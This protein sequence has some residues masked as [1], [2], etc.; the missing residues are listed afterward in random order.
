[1]TMLRTSG[2]RVELSALDRWVTGGLIT[3]DQADRIREFEGEHP[4]SAGR[5][6]APPTPGPSGPSLVIEGLGYLGGVLVAAG[7][8]LLGARWWHHVDLGARLGVLGA[9]AVLLVVAGALVPRELGAVAERL[10]S[11][12]WA[13]SAGLSAAFCGV[14]AH[15]GFDWRDENV[16]ATAGGG[17]AVWALALWT[18]RHGILEMLAMFVGCA[19]TV[20]SATGNLSGDSLP[21]LS[22]WGLAV[23][24]FVLGWGGLL[25][26][27]RV[28][29]LSGAA[30]A[31]IGA[32]ITEGA[33]A[34]M[35]LALATAAAVI[36]LGVLFRDLPMLGVG[37]VGAFSAVPPAIDRWFPGN[38]APV[39]LLVMGLLLVAAAIRTAK[40]F[41]AQES[42]VPAHAWSAGPPTVALG[43]AAAVAVTTT[44]V[45]LVI[46]LT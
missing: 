25:A 27:R 17:A 4:A 29:L 6:T 36:A 15:D 3:A 16:A 32:M 33:D 8:V 28:V 9:A 45:V 20:G 24:W 23:A 5:R 40:R 12:L 38:A 34:G 43:L 44:V 1:M 39:V 31:L 42:D 19:V 11:V 14:L 37:T 41:G 26:P 2:P 7:A 46:G 35:G 30:G 10:R 21:G 22:V 18:R 13:A